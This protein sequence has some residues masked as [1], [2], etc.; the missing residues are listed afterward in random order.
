MN[1]ALGRACLYTHNLLSSYTQGWSLGIKT[2]LHLQ[3]TAHC[4]H[5]IMGASCAAGT[6]HYS[7]QGYVP[8][9]KLAV[10]DPAANHLTVQASCAASQP[11][12]RA[13]TAQAAAWRPM[14]TTSLTATLAAK[15]K[16]RW[17]CINSASLCTHKPMG[18]LGG[19]S[20][21]RRHYLL[22]THVLCWATR[23]QHAG[24]HRPANASLRACLLT[25][26]P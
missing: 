16:L 3:C 23:A 6:A 13:D 12:S 20:G 9:A 7:C 4:L 2:A 11:Q 15:A 1:L 5:G 19:G 26:S 22:Q 17:M 24:L 18:L 10:E 14:Q 8:A 25:L 21:P